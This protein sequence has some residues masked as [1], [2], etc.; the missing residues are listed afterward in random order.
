MPNP[1]TNFVFLQ[2]ESDFTQWPAVMIMSDATSDPEQ[3]APLFWSRNGS[4]GQRL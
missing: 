2:A 3:N 1:N 4:S